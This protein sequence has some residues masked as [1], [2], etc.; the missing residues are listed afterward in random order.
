MERSSQGSSSLPAPAAQT[1]AVTIELVGDASTTG[2]DL[3]QQRELVTG[4][5]YPSGRKNGR[6]FEL[7][8]DGS[9]AVPGGRLRHSPWNA[10]HA[11][12]RSITILQET[13]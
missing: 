13:A 7:S 6:V 5:V 8:K 10:R 2:R 9:V 11:A 1:L 3:H 4:A 12:Q